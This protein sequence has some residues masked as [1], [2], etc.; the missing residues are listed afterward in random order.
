MNLKQAVLLAFVLLLLKPRIDGSAIKAHSGPQG[1][2]ELI[3]TP[4]KL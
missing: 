1:N 2:V 3:K 4:R